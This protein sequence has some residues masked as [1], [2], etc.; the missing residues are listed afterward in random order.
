MSVCYTTERPLTLTEAKATAS[1]A[2]LA[3]FN[4]RERATAVWTLVEM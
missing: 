4:K 2:L 3:S 1:G